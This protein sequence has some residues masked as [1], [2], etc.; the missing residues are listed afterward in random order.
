MDIILYAQTHTHGD[1]SPGFLKFDNA[2]RKNITGDKI[3]RTQM[4]LKSHLS[5]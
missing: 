2:W 5:G 1:K 3:Q 4:N